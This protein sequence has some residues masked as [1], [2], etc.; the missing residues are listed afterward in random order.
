MEVFKTHG[1]LGACFEVDGDGRIVDDGPFADEK[2]WTPYFWQW[3]RAGNA[4]KQGSVFY[5]PIMLED[6][7]AYP[8]LFDYAWM[9]IEH[10]R[11]KVTGRM[12]LFGT[13]T[14]VGPAYE[15]E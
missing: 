9:M 4:V 15:L 14:N 2:L 6:V 8:E 12:S 10:G 11:S 3:V 5:V 1:E 7:R 13:P